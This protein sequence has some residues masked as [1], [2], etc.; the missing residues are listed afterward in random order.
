MNSNLCQKVS[1]SYCNECNVIVCLDCVFDHSGHTFQRI[2]KKSS[3]VRKIIFDYLNRVEEVS[4]PLKRLE[5]VSNE[6]ATKVTT[7]NSSLDE[8]QLTQRLKDLFVSVIESNSQLWL[9]IV[10]SVSNSKI[11]AISTPPL[12]H[13]ITKKRPRNETFCKIDT[14]T[15]KRSKISGESTKQLQTFVAKLD[16]N[17]EN[18]KK[19]LQISD[20]NC[21][22]EFKKSQAGLNMFFRKCEREV[23][24]HLCLEWSIGLDGLIRDSICHLLSSVKFC[25]VQS[26]SMETIAPFKEFFIETIE[27]DVDWAKV[28]SGKYSENEH[29]EYFPAIFDPWFGT[30]VVHFGLLKNVQKDLTV[31]TFMEVFSINIKNVECLLRCADVIAFQT[32]S[33]LMYFFCLKSFK[34][35]CKR[36]LNPSLVPVGLVKAQSDSFALDLWNPLKKTLCLEEKSTFSCQSQ[37][38][39]IRRGNGLIFVVDSLNGIVVYDTKS[40][41]ELRI[42]HLH[43]GL[44]SVDTILVPKKENI[45]LVDHEMKQVAV[46]SI[47]ASLN[48]KTGFDVLKTAKLQLPKS[49]IIH[50]CG[51]NGISNILF[52]YSKTAGWKFK[53]SI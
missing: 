8:K 46:C 4:K 23:A 53:Y 10:R 37:P 42:D 11:E 26:I 45:I 22:A 15:H 7:L 51:F 17:V 13:E 5:S 29:F 18:L 52:V 20:G 47:E 49:S 33:K 3:E 6:S 44:S 34:V 43:H 32:K 41:S 36:K 12:S 16:D 9:D 14:S 31:S 50:Y 25:S 39:L 1:A 27:T 24:R 35:L 40:T 21:I 48:A 19:M 30:D 28:L 38:K 2:S